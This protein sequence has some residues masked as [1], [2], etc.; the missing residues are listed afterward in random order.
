[1]LTVLSLGITLSGSATERYLDLARGRSIA[2]QN[3]EGA[4]QLQSLNHDIALGEQSV[5]WSWDGSRS[6]ETS[7][8]QARGT[9]TQTAKSTQG[10]RLSQKIPGEGQWNVASNLTAFLSAEDIP[11]LSLSP[12]IS[13]ELTIP[14]VV[15]GS[16]GNRL[17]AL[18]TAD[19]GWEKAQDDH[20][21]ARLEWDSLMV[22]HYLQARKAFRD[23]AYRKL[24]LAFQSERVVGLQEL[25]ARGGT[26]QGAI[27]EA[28]SLRVEALDASLRADA[29][30]EG[31]LSDTVVDLGS[32]VPLEWL[33]TKLAP[34]SADLPPSNLWSARQW[35]RERK[36]LE[37]SHVRRESSDAPVLRASVELVPQL[38]TSGPR[39]LKNALVD[40]FQPG[41]TTEARWGLGMTWAGSF[42]NVPDLHELKERREQALL[43]GKILQGEKD[44]SRRRLLTESKWKILETLRTVME[45]EYHR[46]EQRAQDSMSWAAK[47]QITPLDALQARL[48]ATDLWGRWQSAEED[49]VGLWYDER[50][51]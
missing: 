13:A 35:Q 7:F 27:W 22:G 28:E 49:K 26:S 33:T 1:M 9:S 20:R 40:W 48:T 44:E 18:Q 8:P 15:S 21:K 23:Q 14:V 47:G 29:A 30:W 51:K 46:A 39:S 25:E 2:Y 31:A 12:T 45:A 24:V 32:P 50:A 11:V 3:D 10:F 43:D 38:P 36:D 4:L 19:L 37:L 34:L 42:N 16:G 41:V 17:L 5:N 6:L